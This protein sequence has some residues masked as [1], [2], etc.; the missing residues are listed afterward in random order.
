[1]QCGFSLALFGLMPVAPVELLSCYSVG[2]PLGGDYVCPLRCW[3]APACRLP[4]LLCSLCSGLVLVRLPARRFPY[5]VRY[6]GRVGLRAVVPCLPAMMSD[7]SSSL[8]FGYLA[9]LRAQHTSRTHPY[10]ASVPPHTKLLMCRRW[11]G[12]RC[13]GALGIRKLPRGWLAHPFGV[14]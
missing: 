6:D 8:G 4:L 1:M 3:P 13:M 7:A 11:R 5:V 12:K 9:L 2:C 10:R 14:L